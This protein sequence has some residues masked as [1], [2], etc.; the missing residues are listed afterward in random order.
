MPLHQSRERRLVLLARE[1]IQQ[2]AI[3]Q[4]SRR[5]PADQSA[6]TAEERAYLSLRHFLDPQRR[7]SSM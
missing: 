4:L 6:E 7:R 3:A 5:I 2:L 1:A